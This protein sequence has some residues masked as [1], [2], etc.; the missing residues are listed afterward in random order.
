MHSRARQ[1]IGL[2]FLS[3]QR[4]QRL[5]LRFAELVFELA[6]AFAGELHPFAFGFEQ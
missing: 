1:F 2:R 4:M 5:Q 6:P 3:Q